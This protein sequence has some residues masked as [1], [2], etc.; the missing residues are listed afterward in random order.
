MPTRTKAVIIIRLVDGDGD[1]PRPAPV[2]A[3]DPPGRGTPLKIR[4]ADS[5][6]ERPFHL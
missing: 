4:P 2:A 6:L 5:M 3:R 1:H